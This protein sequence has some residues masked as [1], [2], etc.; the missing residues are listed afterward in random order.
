MDEGAVAGQAGAVVILCSHYNSVIVSTVQVVPGAGGGVG[1]TL[2]GV[3][4][5]PSCYGNIC[6][7]AITGPPADGARVKLTLY[8]GR[9]IL[10]DTW[11]WGEKEGGEHTHGVKTNADSV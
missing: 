2:V 9:H 4:I 3:A 10:G 11:C 7:G 5:K 8:V 6:F 1:E